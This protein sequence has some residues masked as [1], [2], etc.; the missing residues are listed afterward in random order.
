MDAVGGGVVV[1]VENRAQDRAALRGE[2]Q[3][4]LAAQLGE[5]LESLDPLGALDLGEGGHSPL[6]REHEG[7]RRQLRLCLIQG[8][9][10]R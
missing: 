8:W 5:P 9:P 4:S 3:L 10:S 2:G 1:E 6:S 7:V